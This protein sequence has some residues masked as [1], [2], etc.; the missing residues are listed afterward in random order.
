[1]GVRTLFNIVGPLTNPAGAQTILMGVFHSDLV[2]LLVRVLQRLGARHALVVWGKDGLDEVSLGASTLVGELKDGQIHEYT[3]HPEDFGFAMASTRQL[4]VAGPDE[5]AQRIRDVLKGV[6]GPSADVV[7]LNAG[8]ALYTA[9]VAESME[10]G[11]KLA[12]DSI[13]SGAAYEKCSALAEL[14]QRLS[15]SK[16][17]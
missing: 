6:P 11:I 7:L 5:S 12:E 1:M 17:P 8:I 10:A 3:I 15:R 2:G 14:T 4:A 16:T 13:K 9:N